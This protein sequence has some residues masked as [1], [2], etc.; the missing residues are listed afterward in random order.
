MNMRN[1]NDRKNTERAAADKAAATGLN[2]AQRR[3]QKKTVDNHGKVAKVSDEAKE[4]AE[5]NGV[6][7]LQV[8][9]P[10]P[11]RAKLDTNHGNEAVREVHVR[12]STDAPAA[13]MPWKKSVPKETT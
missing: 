9:H 4:A 1:I 7:I 5:K 12:S 13:R 3:A 6:Q 10:R 11:Y 8:K 2:R